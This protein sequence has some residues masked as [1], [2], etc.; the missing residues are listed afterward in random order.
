M[1]EEEISTSDLRE[2]IVN[3]L[4]ADKSMTIFR[5]KQIAGLLN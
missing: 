1:I 2:I 4:E 3:M 5:I